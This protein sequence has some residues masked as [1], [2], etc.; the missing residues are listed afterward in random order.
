[1]LT[2]ALCTLLCVKVHRLFPIVEIRVVSAA[3]KRC[4]S[5]CNTQS[6]VSNKQNWRFLQNVTLSLQCPLWTDLC[7]EI[8]RKDWNTGKGSAY[9]IWCKRRANCTQLSNF[10]H[11]LALAHDWCCV[12]CESDGDGSDSGGKWYARFGAR[13]CCSS[14]LVNQ[15]L[16]V[17]IYIYWWGG[18]HSATPDGQFL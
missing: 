7:S 13:S 16:S 2:C 8:Y 10:V 6:T 5:S 18:S 11:V 9:S 12:L 4:W 14:V 15:A 17:Q 1:M 3:V